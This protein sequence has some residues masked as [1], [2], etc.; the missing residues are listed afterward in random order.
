LGTLWIDGR[1]L[2]RGS[3]PRDQGFGV[4]PGTSAVVSEIAQPFSRDIK[5]KL[6]SIPV[7]TLWTPE[8][9]LVLPPAR[10]LKY[11]LPASTAR[12]LV[13]IAVGIDQRW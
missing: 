9:H 4:G 11:F 12:Q 5:S 2:D 3:A 10:L 8:R 6:G 7:G 1:P 13:G